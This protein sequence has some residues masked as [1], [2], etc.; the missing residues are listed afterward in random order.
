[1]K[2]DC[3]K[4]ENPVAIIVIFATQFLVTLDITSKYGSIIRVTIQGINPELGVMMN[5]DA[6]NPIGMYGILRFNVAGKYAIK[7]ANHNATCTVR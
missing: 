2:W 1:M 5:N 7:T 6:A 4:N 3:A